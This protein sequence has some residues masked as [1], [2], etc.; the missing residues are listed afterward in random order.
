MVKG[1]G[2]GS[3]GGVVHFTCP[4]GHGLFLP[5]CRL[6]R[7]D[8]FDVPDDTVEEEPKPKPN[9]HS[10]RSTNSIVGDPLLRDLMSRLLTGESKGTHVHTA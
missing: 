6:K 1:G 8:R 7:D 10:E 4:L 9:P 2:D 3:Y 5:L